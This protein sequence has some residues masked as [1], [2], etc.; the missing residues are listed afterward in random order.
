V[1]EVEVKF[2]AAHDAVRAA[3]QEHDADPAAVRIQRDTYYDAPDRDFAATDEALRLRVEWRTEAA[4][5]T[6]GSAPG[7]A[8]TDTG[9]AGSFGPREPPADATVDLTYKG[10]KVDTESKTREEA[11]VAVAAAEDADAVLR[12]LGYA[13]AATVEKRRER[14]RLEETLVT[15]DWV[16]D[17]GEFVE[18]ERTVDA[19][20]KGTAD[21]GTDRDRSTA[22]TDADV[23]DAVAAARDDLLA[24]ARDL[25]LDPGATVRTSYLG[26]LLGAATDASESSQA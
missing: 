2:R 17:L 10:A 6:N 25:G 14:Y 26:L 13:P 16:V 19:T 7:S 20:A 18:L 5:G 1:Y 15:L 11:T 4:R 21:D 8:P 24:L 3:V 22:A 9:T 23:P 12:G